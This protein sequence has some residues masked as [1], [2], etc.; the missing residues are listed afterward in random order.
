[1]AHQC[2]VMANKHIADITR[3]LNVSK[4]VYH[5]CTHRNIQCRHRLIQNDELRVRDDCSRN[6]DALALPAAELMRVTRQAGPVETNG[7]QSGLR[8][9]DTFFPIISYLV[10]LKGFK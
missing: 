5:L 2:Q 4:Q 7:I 3:T 6:T 1:M 9:G 8:T 10:N